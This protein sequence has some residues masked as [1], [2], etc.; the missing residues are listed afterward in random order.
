[1]H[2]PRHQSG[3][4]IAGDHGFGVLAFPVVLV[5][6]GGAR[7]GKPELEFQEPLRWHDDEFIHIRDD[8]G[9][10]GI[11]D[12]GQRAEA[13]LDPTEFVGIERKPNRSEKRVRA[14][15]TQAIIPST[16]RT[17]LMPKLGE[18][19]PEERTIC[20]PGFRLWGGHAGRQ[21]FPGCQ[22]MF[23]SNVETTS[24]FQSER[25]I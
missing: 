20:I 1:L 16:N 4:E 11:L 22:L 3:V 24:R 7:S 5:G 21:V 12:S 8:V 6:I 2:Y 13:K 17:G 25:R 9:Q 14:I 23:E 18:A 10:T 15:P 19:G